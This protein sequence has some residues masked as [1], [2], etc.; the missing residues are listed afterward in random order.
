MN[1]SLVLDREKMLYYNREGLIPGPLE[2]EEEFVKRALF[3]LNLKEELKKSS[4]LDL[5]FNSIE[6]SNDE[7]LSDPFKT[8]LKLY[9]IA[10]SWVPLFFTNYQLAFWHGG[11]AWIFQ[12]NNTTPFS[13]LLQ[14]RSN[15]TRKKKYLGL[16]E[17]DELIAHEM[18]HVG[19]MLYEE[20]KFDELLAYQTSPSSFR[21]WFGPIAQS[22]R[23]SFIF[24]LVL[25]VVLFTNLALHAFGWI[26]FLPRS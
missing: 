22:S 26:N 6:T 3:C 1:E 25:G 20:P 18:S 2:N 16:Y 17:R 15:F 5:P 24:V 13:A 19:R 12:L 21:R 10:P 11:C 4:E 14:L 8:T 9:G 7:I 23:E